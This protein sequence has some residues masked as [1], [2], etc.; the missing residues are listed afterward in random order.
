MDPI[1]KP[2]ER[3]TLIALYKICNGSLKCHVPR[4]A[5][6]SKF[7]KD[8]RKKAKKALKSLVRLGFVNPHPTSGGI[9]YELTKVGKGYVETDLKS[10][11]N[12]KK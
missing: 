9:T 5:I 8:H 3:Y 10:L 6:Q 7:R 4:E 1:L 11:L 2:V 12:P